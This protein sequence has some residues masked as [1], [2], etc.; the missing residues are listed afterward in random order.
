MKKYEQNQKRNGTFGSMA[1]WPETRKFFLNI[2]YLLLTGY[3]CLQSDRMQKPRLG[4]YWQ[5]E[6]LWG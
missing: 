4:G 2:T 1:A 5:E 6:E 3:D